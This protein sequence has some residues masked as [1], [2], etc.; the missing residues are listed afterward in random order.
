MEDRLQNLALVDENDEDL[1]FLKLSVRLEFWK[2]SVRQSSIN[3]NL[4][5]VGT[6]VTDRPLNFLIM[7]HQMSSFWRLRCVLFVKDLDLKCFFL[8]FIIT[9][10]FSG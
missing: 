5:L 8:G 4:C 6:F 9:M 3:Y 1:E 10:I 2:L 7:K